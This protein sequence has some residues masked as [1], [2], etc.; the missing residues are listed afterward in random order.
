MYDRAPDILKAWFDVVDPRAVVLAVGL[1]V[2]VLVL[3]APPAELPE[4]V[5]LF[6]VPI[7]ELPVWRVEL[8]V[9]LVVFVLVPVVPLAEPFLWRVE[10]LAGSVE[11]SADTIPL[12]P[13]MIAS[14][15]F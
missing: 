6:A 12:L 4:R 5:E 10:L 11:Q 13:S 8:A 14:D 2:F 3:A 15:R 7:A 9:G 1:V